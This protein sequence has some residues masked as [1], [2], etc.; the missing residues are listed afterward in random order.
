MGK[1]DP[2]GREAGRFK[3]D[4]KARWREAP[5]CTEY[6]VQSQHSRP[7][8]GARKMESGRACMEREEHA[9]LRECREMGS[10]GVRNSGKKGARG[11]RKREASGR[12]AET[13]GGAGNAL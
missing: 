5:R 1:A 3:K 9:G 7:F 4:R 2:R 10:E 12:E 6:K 8:G 11:R 13:P